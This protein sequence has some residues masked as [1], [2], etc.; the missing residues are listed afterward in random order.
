MVQSAQAVADYG[1][2]GVKLDGCGQFR[3][4]TWW[5]ELL[6]ATGVHM[7]IEDCHGPPFPT[8]PN[9]TTPGKGGD[10]PCSGTTMPSDCPYHLY[11]TSDD[12]TNTFE[13]MHSNLLSTRPFQGD[14]PLSR[15]GTYS[16]VYQT[17]SS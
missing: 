14:V 1:F 7:L 5:A 6:N 11:R 15:P 16:N 13:S 9:D 4:L 17:I 2:E 10:G 8:W 12:I 3:N